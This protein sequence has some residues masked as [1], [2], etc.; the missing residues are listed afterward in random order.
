MILFTTSL[1]SSPFK[2]V[3]KKNSK[4]FTL[5][6][7]LPLLRFETG[8]ARNFAQPTQFQKKKI[9]DNFDAESA[10]KFFWNSNFLVILGINVDTNQYEMP[11]YKVH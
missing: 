5:E 7:F 11:W 2:I 4:N 8:G 6:I 9:R 10:G 3:V 1:K